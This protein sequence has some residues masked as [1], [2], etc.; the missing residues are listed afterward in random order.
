MT[1]DS[2]RASLELLYNISRE[3]TAALDLRLVLERV[4]L[5]SVHYVEGERGSIVVLDDKGQAVDSAIVY[6]DKVKA[7]ATSQLREIVDR[8]LA[9]WVIQ[10]RKGVIVPD[11]S[12]DE[13]W[14]RRPDDARERSG[15]KSA[16]CVPLL[17]RERLVGVLTVVHPKPG[18]F[19][20]EHFALIQAIADQAGAAVLNARLYDESQRQARVM[21]ALVES[22]LA[23]NA[24]LQIGEV[25][26]RIL[27]QTAQ[28][29]RVETVLLAM[30]DP[31]RQELEI[32][33][34][35]SQQGQPTLGARFPVGQGIAG[36]V[37][38]TGQ[39][40]VITDAAAAG[41]AI[42]GLSVRVMAGAPVQNQGKIIGVLEAV[43]PLSGQFEPDALLVLTGIGS[44]AGSAIHNAQLYGDVE[45]ARQRY[46]EL[47]DDS[48]D[49]ILITDCE[50][51]ILEASRQAALALG[52]TP[53][54]LQKMSI[55]EVHELNQEKTGLRFETVQAGETISY[56][57]RLVRAAGTP[58]PI[59]V[60]VRRVRI[61]EVDCLQWI[62]RDIT[63]RKELD[64]MRDDLIAMVYHDLRST[65]AN[66]VS[67]LDVMDSL[68]P[69]G[70]MSS[71]TALLN[72]AKRSTARIQRLVNSLLDITRLEAGQSI[73]RRTEVNP[74]VLIQEA[75][76]VA[77]PTA[78]GK[79]QSFDLDLPETL[80]TIWADE[81]MIRRVLINLLENA[82]KFSPSKSTIQVGARRQDAWVEF[83][84]LDR[85][86]GIPESM[87]EAIFSK[88]TRL[89][90]E[91]APKGLGL[92]LAF[93]RLA[94]QAHGGKIWVESQAQGGSRFLF[95]MPVLAGAEPVQDSGHTES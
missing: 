31:T 75:V 93:C 92:G 58:L 17:S 82:M 70:E 11:T 43:N 53:A 42:P 54:A 62:L 84:V 49:P 65:L 50:G 48:I 45:S 8:G 41:I 5:L 95:T 56:E 89:H 26:Q 40:L 88:Y 76:D 39:A 27:E 22:A 14:L 23:M 59:Q 68:M 72:I 94:V 9:G 16:I 10:N 4:L 25:L 2:T 7:N 63:E 52:N 61:G 3:L 1:T 29:L 35:S 44:L 60:Y 67:S 20:P 51:L 69:Q 90:A 19:T 24:S 32:R 30:L 18:Y 33:A 73:T 83:W 57:S 34:V 91:G 47:F 87:R 79:S 55:G 64:A 36:R 15:A 37:A 71:A 6:R 80:P 46:Q 74:L 81:D 28:A 12:L 78:Q 85:G 66:V 21:T 77:Q 13:R 38:Q 86:P